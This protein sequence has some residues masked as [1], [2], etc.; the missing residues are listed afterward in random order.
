M[1]HPLETRARHMLERAGVDVN[2]RR[3]WDITVH[4]PKFYGRV[5]LDGSL[6][7]GESYM[8]G[9]WECAHLDQFFDRVMSAGLDRVVARSW[10]AAGLWL[11][12]TLFN[13]QSRRRSSAV[14]RRHYDAGNDIFEA[15]LG[16]RM[17]YT[18]GYWREAATLDAAEEA[19]L[20]CVCRKLE[21]APGMRVLDIGCGWGSFAQFAAE[22]YGARVYGI[23]LSREQRALGEQR[24]A[25]LPVEL[26]LQ[27]YREVRA[28]E[29]FDR[30]VSLGMFE[31]VGY[32]NYRAFFEVARRVL[33]PDGRMY[34]STIGS[35]RTV[36]TTDPWIEKYIFPNSQLPSIQQIGAAMEDHFLPLEWRDWSPDYDRTLMAWHANFAAR[37]EE[38]Q[39]KYG[40]AFCR[41]WQY[42]LLA[43]AAGFRSREMQAWQ[44]VLDPVA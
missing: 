27:D 35:N 44:M 9:W 22:R 34:L 33:R 23:T 6:G 36:H 26:K 25:G 8:D 19:K 11:R 5:L 28:G 17:V 41:M 31:H 24:C 4:N 3:P 30:V 12:A 38:W 1:G 42:Y 10:A 40:L 16:R 29:R 7:L 15:M 32:K 18:T 37:W 13:R 2:G 14:A 43:S 20:D 21:L 39:R